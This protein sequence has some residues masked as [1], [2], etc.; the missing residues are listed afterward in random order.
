M[1][2]RT[3]L[4]R[5]RDD[6]SKEVFERH[7]LDVHGPL[8]R[9]VRHLRAY[10]QNHVLVSYIATSSALHRIDGLSQ[11]WFDEVAVME[12]A[13]ASAEQRACVDD[14][15]EFLSAVTIVIQ[16]P[17]EWRHV[18]V[19]GLERAK[20]MAVLAGDP[21]A[22]SSYADH[23]CESFAQKVSGGGRVRVNQAIERGYSVDRDVPR[24][25]DIVAAIA[26][27]WFNEQAEVQKALSTGLLSGTANGLE[28]MAAMRVREFR[29][30]E[31]LSNAAE[32]RHGY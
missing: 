10:T 1:I 32:H 26:E 25:K 9:V 11:L 31:P 27:L 5:N 4:I 3:G 28:C 17:G 24:G 15:K 7:W 18:G 21:P 13:M 22:S 8:A 6:V 12:Q 2:I 20:V 16:Q 23:L 14:I 29:I 30:L 19:R